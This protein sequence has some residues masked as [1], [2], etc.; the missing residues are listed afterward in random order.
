MLFRDLCSCWAGQRLDLDWY[1]S[2]NIRTDIG[3]G[4]YAPPPPPPRRLDLDDICIYFASK[5]LMSLQC[6]IHVRTCIKLLQWQLICV[7]NTERTEWERKGREQRK[8]DTTEFSVRISLLFRFHVHMKHV[9]SW[10]TWTVVR[11]EILWRK[12]VTCHLLVWLQHDDMIIGY[13]EAGFEYLRLHYCILCKYKTYHLQTS[14]IFNAEWLNIIISFARWIDR[15]IFTVFQR[16]LVT[17]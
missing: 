8:V 1:V 17:Y 12:N 10:L 15:S 5:W 16:Y 13:F 9:V 7:L 2:P 14:T 6:F 11:N 3:I 4:I